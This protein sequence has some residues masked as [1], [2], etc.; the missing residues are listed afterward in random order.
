[1]DKKKLM[2][3]PLKAFFQLTATVYKKSEENPRYKLPV[4]ALTRISEHGGLT[5]FVK[6]THQLEALRGATVIVE[7]DSPDGVIKLSPEKLV[8]Q[9]VD[10]QQFLDAVLHCP[11]TKA[12]CCVPKH[13]EMKYLK[14]KVKIIL[15]G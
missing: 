4:G 8:M 12:V 14:P 9:T 11:D 2:A 5:F 15:P 3:G 1:M 7:F 6:V 10:G 13:Q